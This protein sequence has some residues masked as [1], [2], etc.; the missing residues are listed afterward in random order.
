MLKSI[1][2]LMNNAKHNLLSYRGNMR[3]ATSVCT[4]LE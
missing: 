2:F 3:N 1:S 4:K